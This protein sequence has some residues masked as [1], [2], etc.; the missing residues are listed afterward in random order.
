MASFWASMGI[1]SS[2]QRQGKEA[3]STIAL[4]EAEVPLLQIPWGKDDE[5]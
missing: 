2:T 3:V 1:H 4:Q 5:C